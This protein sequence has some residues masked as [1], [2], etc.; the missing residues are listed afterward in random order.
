LLLAGLAGAQTVVI[1]GNG[2]TSGAVTSV[3]GRTGAVILTTG[4]V[5]GLGTSAL[6][7]TSYFDIFGAAATVSTATTTA[8]ALKAP[9]ASP[10][11]TGPATANNFV[12]TQNPAS[13]LLTFG[14]S[15][16]VGQYSGNVSN[17]SGSVGFPYWLGLNTPGVTTNDCVD[18]SY[19]TDVGQH[20]LFTL[21]P[22]LFGQAPRFVLDTG[23]NDRHYTTSNQQAIFQAAHLADLTR[24]LIPLDSQILP[25]SG[26]VQQS[27]TWTYNTTRIGANAPTLESNTNGATLTISATTTGGP[28]YVWYEQQD[29]N[30]GAAGLTI[31]GTSVGTPN[32]GNAGTAGNC[33]CTVTLSTTLAP[34]AARYA[35][36]AGSHTLVFTVSGATGSG[37][38][39][40]FIGVGSPGMYIPTTRNYSGGPPSVWVSGVGL[41]PGYVAAAI[42]DTIDGLVQSNV[43]QLQLD[44]LK[45]YYVCGLEGDYASFPTSSIQPLGCSDTTSYWL[46]NTYMSISTTAYTS[47][48][49]VL[50]VVM[51]AAVPATV[52]VG[53]WE[54][55]AGTTTETTIS[56]TSF[57]NVQTISGSTLTLKQPGFSGTTWAATSDTGIV[58]KDF[59][60][61]PHPNSNGYYK[62][63]LAFNH[64][65]NLP[66][67]GANVAPTTALNLA[68]IAQ[69]TNYT[70]TGSEGIIQLG[71]T[72]G[73]T[74]TLP[75][76]PTNDGP[77]VLLNYGTG[78][79]TLAAGSGATLQTGF[80]T[81][82]AANQAMIFHAAPPYWWLDSS[83]AAYSATKLKLTALVESANYTVTGTEGVLELGC[84]S[85]MTVTLPSGLVSGGP[86]ILLNYG[87]VAC[88]IAAGSGASLSSNLPTTLPAATSFQIVNFSNNW[89]KVN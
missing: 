1:N 2:S 62:M 9:L 39:F 75:A 69:S 25:A 55:I 32:S 72:A 45:A 30:S 58:S 70:M 89:W 80:P 43:H 88:T 5:G 6:E 54:I 86:Y 61:N 64:A 38:G 14:D 83:T 27:G 22:W 35:V 37:M 74:L 82:L 84:S 76:A 47:T 59:Y 50:S 51:T 57:W 46:D 48:T 7:P 68:R 28:L 31:D 65:M 79:C 13:G 78:P 87:S 81:A 85:G 29:G 11:F 52:N 21:S 26:L 56:D 8:L 4:D 60:S 49:G 71:C 10:I 42:D 16:C 20:Q 77:F 23:L 24:L 73:V 34:L 44:G 18:G 33:I 67:G 15:T 17:G 19:A 36:A 66:G 12:A 63:S 41:D 3:A 53:D 40:S